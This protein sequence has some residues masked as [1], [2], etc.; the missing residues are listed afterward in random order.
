MSGPKARPAATVILLRD[1]PGGCEVLMVRRS[2]VLDFH[3]G[4]WVFP[5]GRVDEEDYQRAGSQDE[6][7]AARY[8]AVR[9]A[10]EE[11]GLD[12]AADALV[13]LSRWVTPVNVPKRFDTWFFAVAADP[14]QVVRTDGGEISAHRWLSPRLALELQ[15]R[16]ELEL[17][18]PTYVTLLELSRWTSV[19]EL[20]QAIARREP[21]HFEPELHWVEGGACTVYRGDV[22]YGNG[23]LDQPGPR[24]RLWMLASGWRYERSGG[25]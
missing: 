2:S 14:G 7:T 11:V 1:S 9:E 23:N 22:A 25:G 21:P 6:L 4:A 17:P 13:P 5:G 18:A 16:G 8:A 15:G 24:H 10:K 3:G 12:I 20:L 19:A